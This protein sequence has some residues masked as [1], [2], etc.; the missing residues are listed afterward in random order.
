MYNIVRNIVYSF[1]K[2]K[3]FDSHDIINQLLQTQAYQ[4]KRAKVRSVAK[5]HSDI[6]K[7]I[8]KCGLAKKIGKANSPTITG[9]LSPNCQ[10]ERI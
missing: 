1:P 10:W 2:G 5:F 6:A 4:Q 8:K 3:R 9:N 7:A